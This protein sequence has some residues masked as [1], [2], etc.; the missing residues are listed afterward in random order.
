MDIMDIDEITRAII[1]EAITVHRDL[2]PGLLE[3]VYEAC[4]VKRLTD[5]GLRVAR[6]VAL[7]V[8][9]RGVRLDCGYRVDLVVEGRVLVELKSVSKLDEVYLAQLLTYLKLSGCAVGLL[10]NFNVPRLVDGL[11][12]VVRGYRD[13]EP[14]RELEQDREPAANNKTLN[15][16]DAEEAQRDAEEM[17]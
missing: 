6:Q 11:R 7:P 13:R 16:E 17:I 10:I 12:R 5:R 9:Y 14:D 15:A 1:G 4:L 8:V 3:A 2:G